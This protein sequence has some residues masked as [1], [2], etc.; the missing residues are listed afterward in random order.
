MAP[1]TNSLVTMFAV[2][3]VKKF[4]LFLNFLQEMETSM[5]DIELTMTPAQ[6]VDAMTQSSDAQS[7]DAGSE[8][9]S[10]T[11]NLDRFFSIL[12]FKNYNSIL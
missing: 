10:L 6:D 12:N 8:A 5:V 4:I 11:K 3:N 2:L 1:T 9:G 7:L